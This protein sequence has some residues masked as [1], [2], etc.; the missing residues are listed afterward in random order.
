MKTTKPL[1]EKQQLIKGWENRIKHHVK[2][3]ADTKKFNRSV[4]LEL[5]KKIRQERIQLAALKK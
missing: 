5:E 2:Q 3:L 4:E 1:S